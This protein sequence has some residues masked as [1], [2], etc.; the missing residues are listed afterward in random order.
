MNKKR[1]LTFIGVLFLIN[2]L[3]QTSS[4]ILNQLVLLNIKTRKEKIILQENRHFEA[5]NCSRDGK[6][7]IIN[8]DGLNEM[9]SV[10][11]EKLGIIKTGFAKKCNN[12]HGFSFDGKWLIISHI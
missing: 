9:V 11:G 2:V 1:T 7:I 8:S 6:F 3:A 4:P 5:P 10:N 12:D